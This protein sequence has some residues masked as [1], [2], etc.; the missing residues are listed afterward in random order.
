V[1]L[2]GVVVLSPGAAGSP[3]V[4]AL[5]APDGGSEQRPSAP[6]RSALPRRRRTTTIIINA[7][8]RRTRRASERVERPSLVVLRK[9]P[10]LR[11][12]V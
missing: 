2:L 10:E 5:I 1:A 8:T 9:Q 3:G 12:V 7:D 11:G 6:Q 4:A